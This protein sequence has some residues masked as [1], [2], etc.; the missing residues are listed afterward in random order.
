MSLNTISAAAP[1]AVATATAAR[2]AQ[3]KT[4]SALTTLSQEATDSQ[5]LS[6]LGGASG[7]PSGLLS[8]LTTAFDNLLAQLGGGASAAATTTP[9]TTTAGTTASATAGTPAIQS[10]VD[11][12]LQNLEGT[13]STGSTTTL[14]GIVNTL[15]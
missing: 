10:F 7:A 5:L 2:N 12:T 11:S 3:T 8:S 14:G 9:P 1:T 4:V 6:S 13:S 15:A